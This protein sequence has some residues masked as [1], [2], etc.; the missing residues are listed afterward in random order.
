M[1]KSGSSPQE[2]NMMCM[3]CNQRVI[4]TNHNQFDNMIIKC[5]QVIRATAK[6]MEYK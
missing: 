1:D 4:F 5:V 2:L 6:S 3:M